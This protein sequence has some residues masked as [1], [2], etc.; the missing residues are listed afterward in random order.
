[1]A[2]YN[3]S[4]GISTSL[5]ADN[6]T[7][8]LLQNSLFSG[9]GTIVM[10]SHANI[11]FFPGGSGSI[12]VDSWGFGQVTNGEADVV[13]HAHV[14]GSGFIC[15]AMLSANLGSVALA[16]GTQTPDLIEQ[17]RQVLTRMSDEVLICRGLTGEL[18]VAARRRDEARSAGVITSFD[19]GFPW[20][21][22]SGT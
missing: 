20:A 12:Q 3:T 7:A 2:I 18:D 11:V 22:R 15:H 16:V 4:L 19:E 10:D 14:V 21:G 17:S 13:E 1:M 8:F 9:I 6:S 5:Y